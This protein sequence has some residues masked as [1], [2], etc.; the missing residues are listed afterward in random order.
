MRFPNTLRGG[1]LD[2]LT[3]N[4]AGGGFRDGVGLFSL[5]SILKFPLSVVKNSL[6]ISCLFFGFVKESRRE[7][8]EDCCFISFGWFKSMKKFYERSIF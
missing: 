7:E 5:K 6:L 3:V 4:L 1:S 2:N 8:S